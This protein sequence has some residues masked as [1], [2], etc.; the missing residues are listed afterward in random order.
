M[1]ED[2]PY[3]DPLEGFDPM[4]PETDP[5][6]GLSLEQLSPE[7]AAALAQQPSEA[8]PAPVEATPTPT[9]TPAPALP[10]GVSPQALELAAKFGDIDTRLLDAVVGNLPALIQQY[11]SVDGV[12][13][14]MHAPDPASVTA[15]VDQQLRAHYEAMGHEYDPASDPNQA[16]MRQMRYEQLY[17][18][19]MGENQRQ[20]QMQATEAARAREAEAALENQVKSL[21][22]KYSFADEAA[23][24]LAAKGGLNPEEYAKSLHASTEAR[25]NAARQD[26]LGRMAQQPSRQAPRPLAGPGTRPANGVQRPDSVNDPAA[27]DR[28]EKALIAAYNKQQ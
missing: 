6:A 13:A 4:T 27:W 19:R 23:I 2:A 10:P 24:R 12:L 5:Y 18:R 1:P 26:V 20:A 11:G 9:E 15:E 16:F 21:A 7:A 14:Q 3:V 25:V 28:Y 17:D 22:A 8:A